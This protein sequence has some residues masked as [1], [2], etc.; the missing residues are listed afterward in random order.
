M[1]RLTLQWRITLL[2][3]IILA[4]SSVVLTAVSMFNA[5]KSFMAL[6]EENSI[7]SSQAVDALPAGEGTKDTMVGEAATPHR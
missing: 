7:Y 5:E 2:A 6:I 1:K 4:I 3:A